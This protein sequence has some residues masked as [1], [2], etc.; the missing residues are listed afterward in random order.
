MIDDSVPILLILAK[1]ALQWLINN[2]AP[3]DCVCSVVRSR[4]R[5][6]NLDD[7]F[8]K[9]TPLT[10]IFSHFLNIKSV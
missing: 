10:V 3:Q 7:S 9:A 1:Q 2:I 5:Q 8:I 6:T 4:L